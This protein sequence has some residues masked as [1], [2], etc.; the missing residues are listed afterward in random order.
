M[1][2]DSLKLSYNNEI[3]KLKTDIVDLEKKNQTQSGKIFIYKKLLFF[4]KLTSLKFS[5]DFDRTS[6]S[7]LKKGEY[8]IEKRFILLILQICFKQRWDTPFTKSFT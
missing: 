6:S 5:R 7:F 1:Q 4:I 3:Q 8:R 2:I